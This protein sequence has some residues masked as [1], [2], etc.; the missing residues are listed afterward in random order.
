MKPSV[1]ISIYGV[2]LF[3][4][5]CSSEKNQHREII[6]CHN[7]IVHPDIPEDSTHGALALV[8]KDKSTKYAVSTG[9]WSDACVWERGVLPEDGE[10]IIIPRNIEVTVDGMI[11]VEL[12][13]IGIHGSLQFS[14]SVETELRVHTLVSSMSG[15]LEIGTEEYPIST[16]FPAKIIFSDRDIFTEKEDMKSVGRGAILMGQTVMY[17]ASKDHLGTL[18]RAAKIADTNILLSEEPDNWDVGDEIVIAGTEMGVP[19]SDERRRI[20]SIEGALVELNEPLDI[21]HEGWQDGLDVHVANLTRSIQISSQNDEVNKRGHVMF[22]NTRNVDIRYASFTSLGRTDKS[23][24]LDDWYFPEF[25]SSSGEPGPSTNIRG[26]YSVHFHRGGVDP[27][28]QPAH[29]EGCVVDNDPGWAYVNHSSNVDFINNVSYDV[30][31]GAFQTE[32]GN[33]QGSFIGNI[34]IRTI[35]PD[36]PI[37]NPETRPVDIREDSQDFAFQGDGFWIHGGGVRLEN[38]IASGCSGHGFIFWTEGL[39]E[40]D[41]QFDE[42][43]QFL[44]ENIPN[45]TLLDVPSIN[46]WWVPVSKFQ[47]NQAYSV[48]KGLALYYVHSTLFEDVSDLTPEY[49]EKVHSTFQDTTIWNVGMMGVQLENSERFTFERLQIVNDFMPEAVGISTTSTVGNRTIW[50]DV[51][52]GGFETGML[53]PTQGDITIRGGTWSNEIDFVITP[54][55]SEPTRQADNRDLHIDV[56]FESLD[57]NI[58]RSYLKLVGEESLSGAW[59][60]NNEE[61]AHRLILIPDRI[62]LKSNIHSEQQVYFTEQDP[63]YVPIREE[64]ISSEAYGQYLTDV[65]GKSNQQLWNQLEMSFAGALVPEHAAVADGIVGGMVS[66]VSDEPRNVPSCLFINEDQPPADTFDSFDFYECW[67]ENGGSVSQVYPFDHSQE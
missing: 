5:G 40:V 16:D 25:T 63:A 51:S 57:E 58:E 28:L 47:G 67:E 29:V 59:S 65:V 33:E 21:H 62:V 43:N 36:Y 10:R 6:D 35:N 52:V 23:V 26:R 32:A 42:L 11:D 50:N 1:I 41:T 44:V 7:Q 66:S 38:N 4:M 39:R 45:G 19:E 61:D 53:V 8:S 20:V 27:S 12:D 64:I 60:A 15:L 14:P 24:P 31:G 34:A 9:D 56:N 3:A 22:M 30:V 2:L 48:N 13:S 37:E 17:G 54:P 49:L 55:Q 18:A 46:V